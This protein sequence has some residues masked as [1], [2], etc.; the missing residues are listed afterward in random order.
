MIGPDEDYSGAPI[1]RREVGLEPGHGDVADA[2]LY[3]TARGVFTASIDGTPVSD[4]VLSPGWTSYEWRLRYRSYDV[5]GLLR[6][7]SAD[8]SGRSRTVVL[9]IELGNGW[10]RSGVGCSWGQATYGPELGAYAQLEITFADGHRQIVTTDESWQAGPS[11]VTANNLYG[12]QA[13]DARLRD[14][15]W[16]RAGFTSDGWGG[17]HAQEFDTATLTPYV[18]PVVRRQEELH[19][20]RVWTSPSGRTLVDFGQNLVGWVR[21]RVRGDAG[22]TV[23]LRHAEVLEN[24]ELGTRP[25]RKAEAT[26]RFVLSGG[27]D[28]FEP[29][30]TFHGFRYVEVDGWPAGQLL[31]ESLIAVAVHSDLRRIGR[32]TCSDDLLNQLHRNVVWGARGNF[33]DLPTDCPQRDERLGWTGDISVFTPTGAFLFD[34]KNFLRDWF[35]DLDAEQRAA[36]GQVA[37]VVPDVLKYVGPPEGTPTPV[38]TA[39]WSDAA[40]WVPWALWQA[41]GDDTVLRESYG[42]MTA[43]L[44]RV[45]TMLSDTGLWDTGHQFGDWL[46]PTAPPNEP[47]RSKVDKG[48]V[49]T[50]CLYRTARI[51]T[52]VATLLGH[53]TDAEEFAALAER[54]REAFNRNYV[55]ADGRIHSDAATGYALAICFD[56]LDDTGRQRAGDRL[57]ELVAEDDYRISTGFAGTPHLC[58]ALAATGHLDDAYRMLLQRQCP[59]WLYPVTMGATTI[60]ERWDSMLPDGSINPGSM[61]SFNHYAL[62]AVADWMHRVIGGIAPVEPGYS[63]VRI[64]PRPGGGLTWA[65]TSLDTPHGHLSVAWRLI[66]TGDLDVDVTVPDGVTAEIDL[67]GR[68]PQRVAG[69]RHHFG[70]ES[71]TLDREPQGFHPIQTTIPA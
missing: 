4:D 19:P 64:A 68:E 6:S 40:A 56:L 51:V 11:P 32:F 57:A 38:T 55:T 67:P 52:D 18:G 15:S 22:S 28:E 46:D 5:T 48:V 66:P 63:A 62:G 36:D 43:H 71:G 1:L 41:Y 54:T 69:G 10:Y 31:D 2:V 34:V 37:Y 33:L 7:T 53:L 29:T 59:S 16:Q 65:E 12:G 60:W 50:A 26:D 9:G 61:T 20:V 70:V 44:R 17:V 25:L 47:G 58:E 14:S 39:I 45:E 27:G 49:A 30:L 23:T 8:S 35:R 13:I 42:A 24:G 3:A 21:C